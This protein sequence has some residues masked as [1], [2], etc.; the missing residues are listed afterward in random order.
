MD[1]GVDVANPH[2]CL[3]R[4]TVHPVHVGVGKPCPCVRTYTRAHL[5]VRM[6][7]YEGESRFWVDGWTDGKNTFVFN[8]L[9]RPPPPDVGWT[10]WTAVA[11][12]PT[13][14][15][16]TRRHRRGVTRQQSAHSGDDTPAQGLWGKRGLE[17]QIIVVQ[18]VGI[19][20]ISCVN[21]GPNRGL[22]GLLGGGEGEALETPPALT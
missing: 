10:G 3:I 22:C 13:R 16:F 11:T 15:T 2:G 6:C 7:T 19:G 20:R 12:G 21:S 14:R 5:C 8:D 18:R 9:R 1:E 17:R 4:P